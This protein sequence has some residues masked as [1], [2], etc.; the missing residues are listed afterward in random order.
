MPRQ[1][2]PHVRKAVKTEDPLLPQFLL[3]TSLKRV[4]CKRRCGLKM[5]QFAKPGVLATLQEAIITWDRLVKSQFKMCCDNYYKWI[6]NVLHRIQAIKQLIWKI[7]V[8]CFYLDIMILKKRYSNIIRLSHFQTTVY[9]TVVCSRPQCTKVA[10]LA[11]KK[12]CFFNFFQLFQ[13]KNCNSHFM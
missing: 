3:R 7:L 2:Y 6:E 10:F 11:L 12:I 4:D 1:G 13:K 5:L 8:L 9:P